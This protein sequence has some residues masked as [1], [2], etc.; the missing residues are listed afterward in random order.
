MAG[1][2]GDVDFA[3][4]R[5]VGVAGCVVAL[6]Q[7]GR[8][9]FGALQRPVLVAP[10]PVQRVLVVDLLAGLQVEPALA[11]LILRP[12]IPGDRQRLVTPAGKGDQVLLQRIDAEGVG[13]LVVG[14][15]AVGA[16]GADHELV[17]ALEEAG[18]DFLVPELGV[19]EIAEHGRGRRCL[20][21]EVVM[22]TRP[23]LEFAFMAG[24]ADSGANVAG[25][26]ARFFGV[27]RALQEVPLGG[28]R[29]H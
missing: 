14:E 6:L 20:H 5:L 3:V 10:G 21:G 17:A 19:G 8:M 23:R 13:D 27:N 9:A 28:N 15:L 2:A 24:L 16:V 7:I 12:G 26:F 18:F 1:L 22:R 4:G 11:A 29:R 25:G